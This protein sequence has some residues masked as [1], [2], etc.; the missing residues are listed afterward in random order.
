MNITYRSDYGFIEVNPTGRLEERNF[1]DLARQIESLREAG[2]EL[3]GILV[4]TKDFPGWERFSDLLAHADF[5][6]ENHDKVNKIAFCTDSKIGPLLQTAASNFAD[7]EVERF[8][9]DEK[10]EAEKW[11][12]A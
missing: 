6:R 4:H 5:A 8:D 1:R 12:L 3:K 9:H 7:A 2:R 11:L 10:D